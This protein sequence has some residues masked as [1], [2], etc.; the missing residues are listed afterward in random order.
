MRRIRENLT[1]TRLSDLSVSSS[2]AGTQQPNRL[3]LILLATWL[4]STI[5]IIGSLRQ[6]CNKFPRSEFLLAHLAISL[7]LA[8]W[9]IGNELKRKS[10]LRKSKV[11]YFCAWVSEY[12][13]I[14]A[15]SRPITQQTPY[16]F[17]SS[18]RQQIQIISK[19]RC[20]ISIN[21]QN[22]HSR[23]IQTFV[24]WERYCNY[25]PC[26]SC[27]TH[28]INMADLYFWSRWCKRRNERQNGRL[29]I[30]LLL[31]LGFNIAF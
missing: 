24:T 15:K 3:G 22:I 17:F 20:T 14:S 12:L 29:V 25:H 8:H 5:T 23:I 26:S 27:K 11:F 9:W 7:S 13:S 4:L 6:G 1:V 16:I 31:E 28:E 21:I 30:V 19:G 18:F 2:F 10:N